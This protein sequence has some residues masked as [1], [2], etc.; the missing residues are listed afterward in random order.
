MWALLAAADY[1]F[2]V[3][4]ARLLRHSDAFALTATIDYRF[5]PAMID[6]LE[7]GV[8]LTLTVKT[9][10]RQPRFWWWDSIVW[11]RDL[12]FRIQYY[13]LAKVYRVIDESNDFQRSFT[14]L[15][16]AL[17][18]LGE[19]QQI[20]LPV[21]ENWRPP[22]SSYAEVIAKLNLERLPWALRV[23]AYFSPEW[24]L[25]SPPYRWLLSD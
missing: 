13:P 22:G 14:Q 6:A 16:A 17:E 21:A 18:A 7:S 4:Q 2:E 1:G 25:R 5:S 9:R 24:R 19:L 10:I 3:R 8:P 15:S 11:R 23:P 12:D 20:A